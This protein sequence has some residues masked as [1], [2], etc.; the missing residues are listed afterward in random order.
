MTY[1]V[2]LNN[3]QKMEVAASDVDLAASGALIFFGPN[4]RIQCGLNAG[5]WA[6]FTAPMETDKS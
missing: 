1:I 5:L 3:G 6:T 4:R 2:Q